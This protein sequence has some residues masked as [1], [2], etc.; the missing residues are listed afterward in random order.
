[1]DFSATGFD[2]FTYQDFPDL[3]N[4]CPNS[5]RRC[6]DYYSLT[7]F[8]LQNTIHSIISSETE[9]NSKNIFVVCVMYMVI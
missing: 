5:S 4:H 9:T 7:R 1:M 3:P 8:G 6:T 2:W